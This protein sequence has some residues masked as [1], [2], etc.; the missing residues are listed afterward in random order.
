MR[1]RCTDEFIQRTR[2]IDAQ[3]RALPR[4]HFLCAN[5]R[6]FILARFADEDFDFALGRLA[7]FLQR[8]FL[9][10][11]LDMPR[12]LREAFAQVAVGLLA[13][14]AT[15]LIRDAYRV[16]ALLQPAGLV[17]THASIGSRCGTI[18]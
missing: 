1:L 14:R 8:V 11:F 16:P 2:F 12:A 3:L 13:D 7:A 10:K 17:T 5:I 4:A 9:G 6:E 18:C 15:I